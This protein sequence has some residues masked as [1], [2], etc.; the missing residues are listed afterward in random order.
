MQRSL[1]LNASL[2]GIDSLRR[3][4]STDSPRRG[5][6]IERTDDIGET[7]KVSDRRV[8]S[9]GESSCLLRYQLYGRFALSLLCPHCSLSPV[10]RLSV[11]DSSALGTL[12]FCVCSFL[13][14]CMLHLLGSLADLGAC[15]YCWSLKIPWS[16]RYSQFTEGRKTARTQ[17]TTIDHLTMVG[18]PHTLQCYGQLTLEIGL[19]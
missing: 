8:A 13:C 18:Q 15:L 1:P 10:V 9:S 4:C 14:G 3:S 17:A 7:N 6:T 16:H 12:F 2:A 19:M 11:I 5:R